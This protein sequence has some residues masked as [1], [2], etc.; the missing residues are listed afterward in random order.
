MSSLSQT[1]H[2]GGGEIIFFLDEFV[3]T[4]D[5]CPC[6]ARGK[7]PSKHQEVPHKETAKRFRDTT[8][9]PFCQSFGKNTMIPNQNQGIFD[10]K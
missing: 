6:D 9:S 4:I 3:S 1:Y 7:N 8:T 2:W 5:P 10:F